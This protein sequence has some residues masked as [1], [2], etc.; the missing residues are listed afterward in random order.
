VCLILSGIVIAFVV[1][2]YEG[3]SGEKLEIVQKNSLQVAYNYDFENKTDPTDI[4][5]WSTHHDNKSDTG[6]ISEEEKHFGNCSLRLEVAMTDYDFNETE[7][8]DEYGSIGITSA[9]LSEV[10]AIKAWVLVPESDHVRDSTFYSHMF[11]CF[12][13]SSSRNIEFFGETE[14]IKPGRW[15]P[16]FL[17]VFYETRCYNCKNEWNC[18]FEWDGTIDALYLTVWSD[19]PYKGSIYFDDITIW[20]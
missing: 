13:D 6:R 16:I 15:T 17:G 5:P 2:F 8:K 9:K 18:S 20:Q 1:G 11:A 12:N 7:K 14:E 10:K 4:D 19:Q 3:S